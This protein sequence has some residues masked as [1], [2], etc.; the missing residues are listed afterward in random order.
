MLVLSQLRET[1]WSA[2][3][4]YRLFERAQVMLDK[5]KYNPR[6]S[7][8]VQNPCINSYR[9]MGNHSGSENINRENQQ[10]HSHLHDQQSHQR[11]HEATEDAMGATFESYML[12][13]EQAVPG[14]FWINDS[15]SPCFS[16]VDQLLSP[17]FYISENVFHS[18]FT[19]YD[20]GIVGAY[21]DINN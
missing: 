4:T 10:Q 6:A 15:G 13:N 11:Q 18:L 7:A 3:V 19:S 2:S 16:N 21:S 5:S 8:Q 12:A 1:Y 20:N 14:S 17:D 9:S